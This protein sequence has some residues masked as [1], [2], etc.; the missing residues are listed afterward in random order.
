MYE[1]GMAAS[2]DD[3]FEA[4]LSSHAIGGLPK[5]PI[6]NLNLNGFARQ[7]QNSEAEDWGK[8]EMCGA[9][10]VVPWSRRHHRGVLK[11]TRLPCAPRFAAIRKT[12]YPT[13]NRPAG[14]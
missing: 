2:H 1:Q 11:T 7:R 14:M 3:V 9:R 10:G 13:R 8:R 12:R 4:L 5:S 6:S